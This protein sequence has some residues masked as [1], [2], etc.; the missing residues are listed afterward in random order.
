MI[1]ISTNLS[2]NLLRD[3]LKRHLSEIIYR[4]YLRGLFRGTI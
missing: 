2:T 1:Y 4:D 3:T